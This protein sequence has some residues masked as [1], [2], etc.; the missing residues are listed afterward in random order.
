M[1]QALC[2]DTRKH[3]TQLAHV[4]ICN[5]INLKKMLDQSI[6]QAFSRPLEPQGLTCSWKLELA[7]LLIAVPILALLCDKT[8]ANC[9]QSA[10]TRLSL[11]PAVHVRQGFVNPGAA[12]GRRD[13]AWYIMVY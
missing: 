2:A 4:T 1:T 10:A 12:Q 13:T 5:E 11:P 8:H 6:D 9:S 7:L 3:S